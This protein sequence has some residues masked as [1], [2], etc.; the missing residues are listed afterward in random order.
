MYVEG[1]LKRQFRKKQLPSISFHT[2]I[3]Q[4]QS[5]LIKS[6]DIVVSPR[7]TLRRLFLKK[8]QRTSIKRSLRMNLT[9]PWELLAVITPGAP[10]LINLDTYQSLLTTLT[11]QELNLA[12]SKL[13]R[14]NREQKYGGNQLLTG[15]IGFMRSVKKPMPDLMDMKKFY[16]L[17]FGQINI[18]RQFKLISGVN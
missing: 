15:L 6:I 11:T 3:S 17:G 5:Y 4:S 10:T 7:I 8:Q 14:I 16:V 18:L 1:D 9:I 2:K 12:C 13:Y